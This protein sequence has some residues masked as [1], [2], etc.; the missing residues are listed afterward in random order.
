MSLLNS[1]ESRSRRATGRNKG[2]AR[3]ERVDPAEMA[4]LSQM[5][6]DEG[7]RLNCQTFAE[8]FLLEHSTSAVHVI[9][10]GIA[11]NSE[12]TTHEASELSQLFGFPS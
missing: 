5:K 2:S 11:N 1:Y 4:V 6:P 3:I 12:L 7:T 8:D 10:I 9:K